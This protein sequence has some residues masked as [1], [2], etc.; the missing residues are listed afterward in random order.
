MDT[1][2][3]DGTG[4]AVRMGEDPAGT[5][6]AFCDL[7]L[8]WN[9]LRSGPAGTVLTGSLR[10]LVSPLSGWESD[11][12]LALARD[13]I[14]AIGSPIYDIDVEHAPGC[15]D[16]CWFRILEP[17]AGGRVLGS[18]ALVLTLVRCGDGRWRIHGIGDP[19]PAPQIPRPL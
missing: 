9:R 18:V 6:A 2:Q 14:A 16:V 3:P 4:D 5:A 15:P 19:V 8:A 12:G 10:R 7:L 11:R 13:I 17:A 1:G